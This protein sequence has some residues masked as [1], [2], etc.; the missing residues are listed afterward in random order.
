MDFF[1]CFPRTGA[2]ERRKTAPRDLARGGKNACSEEAERPD[3][4]RKK[5]LCPNLTI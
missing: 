3:T 5:R 1:L 4:A 2:N